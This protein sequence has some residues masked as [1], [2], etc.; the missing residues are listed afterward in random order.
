[1]FELILETALK[2]RCTQNE[3]PE[4]VYIISDMEFDYCT[5][6]SNM[7]NFEYA[8][9]LFERHG[10]RLPQIVF[11]NVQSRNMN[12]PVTKNEEGV[13]LVSGCSPAIFKMVAGGSANPY[14]FMVEILESDRY[15]NIAA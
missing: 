11:W 15:K 12:H 8:K 1:M 14:K 13:V 9:K 10:Y 5:E 7:T 4:K 6:D 2:N 3:L